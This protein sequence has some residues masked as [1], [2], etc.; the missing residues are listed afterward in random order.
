MCAWARSISAG[1]TQDG[2]WNG[3]RRQSV[4]RHRNQTGALKQLRLA[5]HRKIT[6]HDSSKKSYRDNSHVPS[7]D[8]LIHF[9][10]RIRIRS[11][12][13]QAESGA[14]TVKR[15]EWAVSILQECLLALHIQILG[16]FP[17]IGGIPEFCLKG[18]FI[19]FFHMKPYSQKRHE[20]KTLRMLAD[21]QPL[22]DQQS[23]SMML[24]V[25]AD[26]LQRP[27]FPRLSPVRCLPFRA[28]YEW[29]VD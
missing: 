22:E 24:R 27:I 23:R 28:R 26:N 11:G 19:G 29:R 6:S 17:L 1:G 7:S 16:P 9:K 20:K 8:Y 10:I 25:D 5:L 13:S 3:E 15:T 4:S 18:I 12:L 21:L 2:A 14:K